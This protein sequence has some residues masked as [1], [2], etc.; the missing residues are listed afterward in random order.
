[1]EIEFQDHVKLKDDTYSF[2][3]PTVIAPKYFDNN[4]QYV[5]KQK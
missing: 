5:N 3:L 1:M 4:S 2:R